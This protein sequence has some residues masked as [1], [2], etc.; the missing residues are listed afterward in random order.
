MMLRRRRCGLA[1]LEFRVRHGQHRCRQQRFAQVLSVRSMVPNI[2]NKSSIKMR[3]GPD[4]IVGRLRHRV[5]QN[6]PKV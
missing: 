6:R 3:A 1:F 5:A 2:Q 4:N